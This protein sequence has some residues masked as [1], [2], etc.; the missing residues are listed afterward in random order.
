MH[1]L[2]HIFYLTVILILAALL[3]RPATDDSAPSPDR[4]A[5]PTEQRTS[6]ATPEQQTI[7]VDS[8][9]DVVVVANAD[10]VIAQPTQ[11]DEPVQRQ[12]ETFIPVNKAK[13]EHT[14]MSRL[15][16]SMLTDQEAQQRMLEEPIDQDWA[17]HMQTDIALLFEQT[18][19][20]QG[21]V[22]EG[23][24]CRTTICEVKF[25]GTDTPI[26]HMSKFHSAMYQAPW[27]QAN[28][29]TMMISNSHQPFHIIRIVRPQ[30]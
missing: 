7:Q 4:E 21:L 10:P 17:H 14:E 25:S 29:Q 3:L 9:Q 1:K 30:P 18:E 23:V 5:N 28:L 2:T 24:D 11:V 26:D 12:T 6:E 13:Q 22:L 8:H 27:Y 20:L 16:A 19:S 15:L